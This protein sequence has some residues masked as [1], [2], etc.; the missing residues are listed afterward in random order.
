MKKNVFGKSERPKG[1][2]PVE[3]IKLNKNILESNQRLMASRLAVSLWIWRQSAVAGSEQNYILQI[4]FDT[5]KSRFCYWEN[6]CFNLC[7]INKIEYTGWSYKT[8][9][10]KML[11]AQARFQPIT[12]DRCTFFDET[13]TF[14]YLVSKKFHNHSVIIHLVRLLRSETVKIWKIHWKLMYS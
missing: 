6:W 1:H 7:R 11:I 2:T 4:L 8:V 12:Y 13:L 3:M 5:E 9:I 10:Y 14:W